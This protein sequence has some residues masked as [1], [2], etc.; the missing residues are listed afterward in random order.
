MNTELNFKQDDL[1]KI[2]FW[3]RLTIAFKNTPFSRLIQDE[4]NSRNKYVVG[5]VNVLISRY[6]PMND[7]MKKSSSAYNTNQKLI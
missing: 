5:L 4:D 7:K 6:H 2:C 1:L 3:L